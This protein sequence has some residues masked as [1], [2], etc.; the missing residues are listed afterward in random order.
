MTVLHFVVPEDLS[1]PTGGNIYDL[2]VD[3]GLSSLGWSVRRQAGVDAIP[4]GALVLVDGLVASLVPTDRF[5]VVVLLHMPLPVPPGA[6]AVITTSEWCRRHM[7]DEHGLDPDRVH[8]AA[9]GAEPAALAESS[10][11]GDRLLCVGVV[12]RHKGHDVLVEALAKLPDLPW[13]CTCIGALNREPSFVSRLVHQT[14]EHGMAD[15]ITFPGPRTGPDLDA[16]YAAADLLVLP[17]RGESYGMVVTEALARGIP[18]V[19]TR[20]QGVPEALGRAPDGDVPGILVPPDD[21]AALAGALRAW[22][23]QPKLRRA[24]RQTARERRAE[25]TGWEVTSMAIAKVLEHH[26]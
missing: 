13:R 15:R 25:L 22:L 23:E 18:V 8:V 24:L 17:T 1:S 6:M 12:A 20:V 11:A 10:E 14:R 3:A 5:R 16:G 19:A 9:P 7:L 21:P 4:D 26:G 2:R